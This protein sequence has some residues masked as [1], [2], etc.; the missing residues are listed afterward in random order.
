MFF[1]LLLIPLLL[2]GFTFL[3]KSKNFKK[4]ENLDRLLTLKSPKNW[5]KEWIKIFQYRKK[6][7]LGENAGMYISKD[8]FTSAI[9]GFTVKGIN[10]P[11]D[12]SN[13]DKW[14]F[15]VCQ[16]GLDILKNGNEVVVPVVLFYKGGL[17]G[18]GKYVP[19]GDPIDVDMPKGGGGDGK[20]SGTS[21][22]PTRP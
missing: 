6:F 7:D 9:N 12:K 16:M 22:P 5:E 4:Q 20:A 21:P 18:N 10:L 13:Y 15:V 1:A 17:D 8:M 14:D 11:L 3:T 2:F 19:V